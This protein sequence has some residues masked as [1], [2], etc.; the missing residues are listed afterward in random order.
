M[1][2]VKFEGC[3]TVYAENQPEYL[4]LPAHR[5]SEGIVTSCWQLSLWERMK[6]FFTGQIFLQISTFNK[7]LQPLKMSI[8]NPLPFSEKES[9]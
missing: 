5:S 2:V 8:E 9:E 6:V 1:K 4:P 3:N 7:S